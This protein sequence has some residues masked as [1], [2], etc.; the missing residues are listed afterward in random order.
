[1]SN[2]TSPR[3]INESLLTCSFTLLIAVGSV[4][5]HAVLAFYYWWK[6]GTFPLRERVHRQI[7]ELRE[8]QNLE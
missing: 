6:T 2:N 1:M 7:I 3:I 8:D 4:A 5:A